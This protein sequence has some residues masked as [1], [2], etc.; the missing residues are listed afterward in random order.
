MRWRLLLLLLPGFFFHALPSFQL[1]LALTH[2]SWPL[3]MFSFLASSWMFFAYARRA[4]VERKPTHNKRKDLCKQSR[5]SCCTQE[6]PHC[7][8]PISRQRKSRALRK[9]RDSRS[10]DRASCRFSPRLLCETWKS[11][12]K[13]LS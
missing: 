12:F 11:A 2:F 9:L 7:H 13:P 5:R 6:S 10:T 8:A 4:K 1:S 3:P